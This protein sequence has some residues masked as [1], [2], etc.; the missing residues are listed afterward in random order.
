MSIFIIFVDIEKALKSQEM[1]LLVQYWLY[2]S[3]FNDTELK[4]MPNN[5]RYRLSI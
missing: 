5:D 3:K 4:K 1:T 2:H